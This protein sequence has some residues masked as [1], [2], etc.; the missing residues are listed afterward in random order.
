MASHVSYSILHLPWLSKTQY[1]EV[2]PVM[3]PRYYYKKRLQECG[4]RTCN[5]C[6]PTLVKWR[7][8]VQCAFYRPFF[9][10]E[11]SC[12]YFSINPAIM[13][14][15]DIS[16]SSHQPSIFVR[17]SQARLSLR[18]SFRFCYGPL[19]WHFAKSSSSPLRC[20]RVSSNSSRPA[21]KHTHR[22]AILIKTVCPQSIPAGCSSTKK[23]LPQTARC[24]EEPT[25]R[26]YRAKCLSG[27][28]KSVAV[29]IALIVTVVPT[30]N[31]SLT[32]LSRTRFRLILI[33]AV[34]PRPHIFQVVR[35]IYRG[36]PVLKIIYNCQA[37]AAFVIFIIWDIRTLSHDERVDIDVRKTIRK[38][39]AD[40]LSDA[41]DELKRML[42]KE[43]H[44]F[45]DDKHS[46]TEKVIEK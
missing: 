36:A 3:F 37:F 25:C 5:G 26:L 16:K 40:P 11:K 7:R 28:L 46:D 44:L 27:L 38:G 29:A 17:T 45:V 12:H 32:V 10:M 42:R 35:V 33:R 23:S 4:R 8:W 19:S 21:M 18:P 39:P 22:D 1:G 24:T 9:L 15:V 20:Q 41:R 34:R 14:T 43:K 30:C 31:I 13:F 2:A 6:E